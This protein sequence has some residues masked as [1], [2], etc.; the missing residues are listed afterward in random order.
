[1]ASSSRVKQHAFYLSTRPG[2]LFCIYRSPLDRP[3]VGAIVHLPAF[4]DEMNKAR[5]MTARASRAFATLGYGVLQVDLAGCGDSE[6]AHE[7]ATMT[8]WTS[9]LEEAIAWLAAH[10]VNGS[11]PV[12]WALR[13]GAFLVPRLLARSV[14]D[15]ALLLWQPILSGT[16][17]LTHLLR[18]KT[19]SDMGDAKARMGTGLL[20]KRLEA[21][22]SLEIGGYAMSPA[23]AADFDA[24]S[25]DVPAGYHGAIDWLEIV[26]SE[27][28]AFPMAAASRAKQLRDAGVEIRCETILGPGFWQSVEIEHCDALIE[29]STNALAA[30]NDDL[31]RAPAVI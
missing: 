2:R 22:E 16:Q 18:Q 3:P 30:R 15:A 13:A 1:M 28:P 27:P 4:G 19:V 29:S 9:N 23:L 6:G 25:F 24:S 12:L 8:Q 26:R 17:Y 11:P 31:R 7:H 20:R 14:P 5:A 21:G 10:A